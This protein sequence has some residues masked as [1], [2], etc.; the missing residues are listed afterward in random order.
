MFAMRSSVGVG[1]GPPNVPN[2]PNPTSSSK[3]STMFG[4]PT[5]ALLRPSLVGVDSEIKRSALPAN[6]GVANGS[7]LAIR[8]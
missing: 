2:D 8:Q 4:A 1:T 6:F 5:G 7:F 3:M